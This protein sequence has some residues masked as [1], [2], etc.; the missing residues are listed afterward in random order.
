MR[1]HHPS[2]LPA[3]PPSV[4]SPVNTTLRGEGGETRLGH[5]PFTLPAP[6]RAKPRPITARVSPPAAIFNTESLSVRAGGPMGLPAGRSGDRRLAGSPLAGPDAAP[7]SPGVGSPCPPPPPPPA[8]GSSAPPPS[9][10]SLWGSRG[11]A[12]ELSQCQDRA[13]PKRRAPYGPGR[14]R[15]SPPRGQRQGAPLVSPP[16]PRGRGAPPS[17]LLRGRVGGVSRRP[18][19]FS[20]ASAA[21]AAPSSPR[22]SARSGARVNVAVAE[23]PRQPSCLPGHC[24]GLI[25]R[26]R[27]GEGSGGEGRRGGLG[28]A[29]RGRRLREGRGGGVEG[30]S[31]VHG[32]KSPR[33]RSAA[34]DRR[35]R[36]VL[37]LAA[38]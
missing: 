37:S 30:P 35:R 36:L 38:V 7:P 16:G 22:G 34:V 19:L 8:L 31:G 25:S 9:A 26:R 29:P 14:R 12:P 18:A 1:E 13:R 11:E 15:G 24:A 2:P 3:P 20:S 6:H 28:A 21:A 33:E 17:L 10:A 32:R 27:G 23:P 4:I 5:Q